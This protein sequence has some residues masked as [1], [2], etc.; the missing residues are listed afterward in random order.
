MKDHC[1]KCRLFQQAA[2]PFFEG[3]GPEGAEI[4]LVLDTPGAASDALGV[5]LSGELGKLVTAMLELAKI[6]ARHVYVTHSVRC[7]PSKKAPSVAQNKHCSG[8]LLEELEKL[9]NLKIVVTLGSGPLKSLAGNG[10][11]VSRC[12]GT[13]VDVTLPSGKEVKVLPTWAPGFIFRNPAAESEMAA[14]FKKLRYPDQQNDTLD[15]KNYVSVDN[16]DSRRKFADAVAVLKS[17]D[18]MAFDIETTGLDAWAPDANVVCVSFALSTDLDTAY[19]VPILHS[20]FPNTEL[21]VLDQVRLCDAVLQS[22]CRKV[23]HNGKFDVRYLMTTLGFDEP[24]NW[25][26]DTR[27]AAHIL[28][29]NRAANQGNSLKALALVYTDLG[30]YSREIKDE[31]LIENLYNAPWVT[32]K[33]YACADAEATLRIALAQYAEAEA[34]SMAG[35]ISGLEMDKMMFCLRMEI[36]GVDID[37]GRLPTVTREME[38]RLSTTLDDLRKVPEVVE[39]EADN[40]AESN[41]KK[42]HDAL[43]R[44]GLSPDPDSWD[45]VQRCAADKVINR[46]A[47]IP[48]HRCQFNPNSAAQKAKL[49]YEYLGINCPL[50]TDGGSQSVSAKAMTQLRG[51]LTDYQAAIV[52]KLERMSKMSKL[53]STY[54]DP[55]PSYRGVDGRIRSDYQTA[56]TV[57]GRLSSRSPNMQNIPRGGDDDLGSRDVKQLMIA[58][59]GFVLVACDYA[60]IEM[61]LAAIFS[62]DHKMIDLINGGDIHKYLASQALKRKEEDIDKETRTMAKRVNFGALY[63]ISPQGL[64]AQGLPLDIAQAFLDTFWAEFKD[65]RRWSRNVVVTCKQF[66]YIEGMFGH[67]RRLPHINSSDKKDAADAERQ[68]INFPIQNA[69]ATITNIA[70]HMLT[71]VAGRHKAEIIMQ[72]HDSIVSRVRKT[73][74]AEYLQQKKTI[75]MHGA[76]PEVLREASETF[77]KLVDIEADCQVGRNL[78]DMEEVE[79]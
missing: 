24:K 21:F 52:D 46:N 8:F 42:L 54:I 79:W 56:T 53:K 9:P 71:N 66:G 16:E 6:P 4:A 35:L 10:Y 58:P 69:A 45:E 20:D 39:L 75:M 23:A 11:A 72:V 61:R 73:H 37:W 77:P 70:G 41:A 59:E 34:D 78:Y 31:E 68:A 18:W 17:D 3:S 14:D 48:E 1:E 49:L 36:A 13:W 38:E 2:T 30:D 67:R 15:S 28:D 27:T 47:P 63:G 12:R 22:P 32:L 5:P 74:L 64:V 7:Q 55:L 19:V 26:W 43:V 51:S 57:T 65:F 60:Q 44:A 50:L 29:E 33:R 62:Q 76:I 40:Y 25:Y